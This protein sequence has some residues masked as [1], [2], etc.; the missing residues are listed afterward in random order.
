MKPLSSPSQF[1]LWQERAVKNNFKEKE[2]SHKHS[3]FVL[4]RLLVAAASTIYQAP[5]NLEN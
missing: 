1:I 4:V 3:T 2:L 5:H